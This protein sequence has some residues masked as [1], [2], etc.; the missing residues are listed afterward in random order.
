MVD[1]LF[2]SSIGAILLLIEIVV[3]YLVTFVFVG[4]LQRA[5][6]L[7]I[8]AFKTKYSRTRKSHINQIITYL[9]NEPQRKGGDNSQYYFTKEEVAE[10]LH[11]N[12]FYSFFNLLFLLIKINNSCYDIKLNNL[13]DYIVLI[14]NIRPYIYHMWQHDVEPFLKLKYK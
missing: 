8:F 12:K 13:S 6:Q 3:I 5:L 1:F 2:I 4:N 7:I 11:Y 14:N 10:I 9:V